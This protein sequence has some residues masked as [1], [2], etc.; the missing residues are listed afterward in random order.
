V[1]P[2]GEIPSEWICAKHWRRLTRDQRRAWHRIKRRVRRLGFDPTPTVSD[3]IWF[4]LKRKAHPMCMTCRDLLVQGLDLADRSKDLDEQLARWATS[5]SGS[6]PI[7]SAEVLTR[8][9]SDLDAW[10]ITARAHLALEH[11]PADHCEE[12]AHG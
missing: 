3:R 4:A 6:S 5:S 1:R 12:S 9:D 7:T 8:Y 2:F 11:D 10:K